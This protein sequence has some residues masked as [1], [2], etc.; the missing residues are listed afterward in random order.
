MICL[1]GDVVPQAAERGSHHQPRLALAL[2]HGT[3]RSR[4]PAVRLVESGL[5]HQRS[6]GSGLLRRHRHVAGSDELRVQEVRLDRRLARNVGEVCRQVGLSG[7]SDHQVHRRRRLHLR[8]PL[9]RRHYFHA[10]EG[11][12]SFRLFKIKLNYNLL[13]YFKEITFQYVSKNA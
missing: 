8:P 6:L 7:R 1:Q 10:D 13:H 2:G 4:D 9:L 5:R 11:N 3:T 12:K